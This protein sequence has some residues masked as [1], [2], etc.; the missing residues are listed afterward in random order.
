MHGETPSW[1]MG[2]SWPCSHAG[3]TGAVPGPRGEGTRSQR[4]RGSGRR[5]AR[6]PSELTAVPAAESLQPAWPQR[7]RG[8]VPGRSGDARRSRKRSIGSQGFPRHLSETQTHATETAGWLR[9]QG[10]GFHF[11]LFLLKKQ[12]QSTETGLPGGVSATHPDAGPRRGPETGAVTSSPQGGG[13]GDAPAPQAHRL[14][15]TSHRTAMGASNTAHGTSLSPPEA[16]EGSEA[17]LGP[18]QTQ[19][20]PCQPN[21]GLKAPGSSSR[22]A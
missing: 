16:G 22:A 6:C 18:G 2:R 12:L 3:K 17:R 21:G 4:P 20:T 5:P 8:A 14:A 10:A 7:S 13:L 15:V 9:L 1:E 19:V 11:P